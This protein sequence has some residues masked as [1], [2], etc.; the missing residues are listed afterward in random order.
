[1]FNSRNQANKRRKVTTLSNISRIYPLTGNLSI[2]SSLAVPPSRRVPSLIFPGR[3]WK[4]LG[5][6]FVKIYSGTGRGVINFDY[7][8]QGGPY[9]KGL[10]SVLL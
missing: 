8:A 3:K 2:K 4:F 9:G 10:S 7:V 5:L 6:S 1:M